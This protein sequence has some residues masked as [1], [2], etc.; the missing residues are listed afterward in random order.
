MIECSL[1]LTLSGEEGTIDLT[2]DLSIG[3]GEFVTLYG[4]SGCGKTTILRMLAGLTAPERGRICVNGRL[5][6]DS[7]KKFNLPPQKR[8]VGFVFQDYALFPAMTV[9]QNCVFALPRGSDKS[10]ADDLLDMVGMRGLAGC[11]PDRLAG[12]QKQR[13]A[14]A[15]ALASRPRFLLLDEPL[16]ALDQE[17]RE[18]L[19]AELE[20]VHQKMRICTI[21]VSHDLREIFR[22]SDK[23]F[24]ICKG[25]IAAQDTPAEVFGAKSY[26][27]FL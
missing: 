26:P 24:K 25:K 4:K 8:N 11:Y 7:E 13:V 3:D 12:G 2:V 18:E 22:L 15:R 1:A 23:V 17:T 27:T 6:F 9:R 20:K 16:S 21:L 14:L 10:A 19:H 5:W